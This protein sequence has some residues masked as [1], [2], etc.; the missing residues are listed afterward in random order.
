MRALAATFLLALAAVPLAGST[1]FP[2]GSG[3]L[4]PVTTWSSSVARIRD[5]AAVIWTEQGGA[6]MLVR[7]DSTGAVVGQ[8]VPI[9][10]NGG[11]CMN[12]VIAS[13]P[14]AGLILCTA[15]GATVAIRVTDETLGE[16]KTIAPAL[17]L[18]GAIWN[19]RNYV[20]LYGDTRMAMMLLAA[21]GTPISGALVFTTPRTAYS[22]SSMA[23]GD[24]R[25]LLAFAGELSTFALINEA[26][27]PAIGAEVALRL[28][29]GPRSSHL[30][31]GYDTLGFYTLSQTYDRIVTLSRHGR[32][33]GE[34]PDGLMTPLQTVTFDLP[35]WNSNVAPVSKGET[36]YLSSGSGLYRLSGSRFEE[37]EL[38]PEVKDGSAFHI[39][40]FSS[41]PMLLWHTYWRELYA[42]WPLATSSAPP[43]LL[44]L[45]RAKEIMPRIARGGT[46]WLAAWL[47]NRGRDDADSLFVRM[48]DADGR[49]RTTPVRIAQEQ[50]PIT[51]AQLAFDGVNY[52]VIWQPIDTRHQEV[53][54]RF[55]SQDGQAVGDVFSLDL[56]TEFVT[57]TWSGSAYLLTG[58]SGQPYPTPGIIRL[59]PSGVQLDSQ[60]QFQNEFDNAV[61]VRDPES[62]RL[63]ALTINYEGAIFGAGP[64]LFASYDQVTIDDGTLSSRASG[65]YVPAWRQQYGFWG[66][67]IPAYAVGGADG[68]FHSL[69]VIDG[70]NGW[71]PGFLQ[72]LGATSRLPYPRPERMSRK[73]HLHAHW[74]GHEFIVLAAGTL[75][76]HAPDGDLLGTMSLGADVVDS[77]GDDGSDAMIV[78][79]ES[80][81]HFIRATR[82]A[83]P[84][85]N[86]PPTPQCCD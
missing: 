70:S 51:D 27:F 10:A 2:L 61:I 38:P 9:I 83:L 12:G 36:I 58:R 69:A 44:S 86:A 13:S 75:A 28:R 68:Y 57:L 72:I 19:G 50:G 54:G 39:L 55:I 16:P 37:L 41:G 26:D 56:D 30:K 40:L 60:P 59:G 76:R 15:N 80:A 18:R 49:P 17:S 1:S 65:R 77:A 4:G 14:R 21:D 47:E 74:T 11:P 24:T 52:L 79:T 35:T 23:C 29:V 32:L 20:V 84:I 45:G 5:G 22:S 43:T 66:D 46:T 64:N 33:R 8:P 7:L 85:S 34:Y 82:V 63:E 71:Q 53:R 31:V 48:L 3:E 67:L 73:T 42:S 62:E 81:D 6:S 78:V 25:C